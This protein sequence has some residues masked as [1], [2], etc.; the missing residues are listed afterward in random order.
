MLPTGKKNTIWIGSISNHDFYNYNEFFRL[1][2]KH[3]QYEKLK[4]RYG[5]GQLCMTAIKLK[6]SPTTHYP[7]LFIRRG[8]NQM[9]KMEALVP[10]TRNNGKIIA[11][12]G[13][14]VS[15]LEHLDMLE[16]LQ[17]YMSNKWIW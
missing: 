17:Y 14:S 13:V 7:I 5:D 10:A 1:I 4:M 3:T 16:D 11:I 15:S 9:I 8:D 2:K 12:N 6:L